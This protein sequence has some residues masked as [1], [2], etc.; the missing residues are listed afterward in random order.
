LDTLTAA[1]SRSGRPTLVYIGALAILSERRR[2]E[3]KVVVFPRTVKA[4]RG[5]GAGM[6]KA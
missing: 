2:S 6:E 5:I 1:G 4:R 3:K